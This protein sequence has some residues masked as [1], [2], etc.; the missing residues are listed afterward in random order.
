MNKMNIKTKA[1]KNNKRQKV[2]NELESLQGKKVF[3]RLSHKS[4]DI[5]VELGKEMNINNSEVIFLI[6]N[7]LYEPKRC[8]NSDKCTN[9]C[10]LARGPVMYRDFCSVYCKN[11]WF[12]ENTDIRSRTSKKAKENEKKF[13][14]SGEKA[15]QIK[16]KL[17]TQVK[18]GNMIPKELWDKFKIYKSEVYKVTNKQPLY[19]L[20][21]FEKR[22]SASNDSNAHHVDHMFSIYE[23]FKQKI[24]PF[25][26]GNI[27]NLEM[28]HYSK[29]CSKRG[30]CSLT[31]EELFKRFYNE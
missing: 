23:G 16:K 18:N 3:N 2:K 28:I 13:R 29:N 25:I 31:K 11:I 19:M 5:V 4:K 26:I 24:P 14:E 6:L 20:E 7:N 15:K 9:F 10:S 12:N 21:N 8:K 27:C 1:D 17:L 22:G 30:N